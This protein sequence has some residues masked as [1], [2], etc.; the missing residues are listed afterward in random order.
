M[1]NLLPENIQA[2]KEF[3]NGKR[4]ISI[5]ERLSPIGWIKQIKE[6]TRYENGGDLIWV[7]NRR[8]TT[9][10]RSMRLIQ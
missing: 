1:D 7:E 8:I 2:Y 10:L 5:I 9:R 6:V 4:D 3:L